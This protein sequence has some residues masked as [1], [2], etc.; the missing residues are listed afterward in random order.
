M[1][2]LSAEI[3]TTDLK[4]DP[5]VQHSKKTIVWKGPGSLTKIVTQKGLIT[6]LK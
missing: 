2:S 6:K 5:L 3:S 1:K 4:L